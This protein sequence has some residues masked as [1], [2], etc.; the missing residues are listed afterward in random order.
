MSTIH[1]RL[2]MERHDLWLC[3]HGC[4]PEDKPAILARIAALEKEREEEF[5][6][7]LLTVKKQVESGQRIECREVHGPD[8]AF[9]AT[10]IDETLADATRRVN[11]GRK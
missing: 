5:A 4:H 7:W 10:L 8:F 3:E 9:T 11:G 6:E 2:R 1:Q